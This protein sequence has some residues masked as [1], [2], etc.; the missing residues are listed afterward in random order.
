MSNSHTVKPGETL[1]I[2]SVKYYGIADRWTRIKNGNPQLITRE[3]AVDGLPL[4][5][6]G[7]VLIIPQDEALSPS[8]SSPLMLS[9]HNSMDIAIYIDGQRFS[10]F[11]G[12]RIVMPMDGLDTFSFSAPFDD[13]QDFIRKAF[14]PFQYKICKVCYGDKLI[15]TGKLVTSAPAVS[16]DAKTI[17]IQGYPIC[18]VLNDC[19]LPASMYPPQ[20]DNMN[21][22]QIAEKIA[23]AFGV[24]VQVDGSPGEVFNDVGYEPGEKIL[25]F[26]KKLTDQRGL[27][28]TN[29]PEGGLLFWIPKNEPVS[30]TFKEGELPFVSCT[31]KFAEQ[32]MYSHITGFSKVGN[33]EDSE[34]FTYENKYLTKAGILRPYSYV[35]EDALGGTLEESVK[36]TAG[37]MFANCVSYDLTVVGHLD[38]NSAL[39]RKN[40]TVSVLSPG[41]MI[42][43]ETKLQVNQV[44]LV[45]TNTEG[46]H[47]NFNLVLPDS[48]NGKLPEVFPW[49]E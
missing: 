2:I 14:K 44:E 36:A 37:R 23:S 42:Y 6:P 12:C 49:E 43:K 46:N 9:D 48:R 16:P 4:I 30:A 5:F 15:F 27:L 33:K 20:Y 45:Q 32:N 34:S 13:T 17:T 31:P 19:C 47:T 38:K 11:S 24:A 39:Y 10:G 7:D 21:L 40:M 35:V 8:T 26:I 1:G 18:G 22:A 25:D 28:F 29:S 3:K 41:A